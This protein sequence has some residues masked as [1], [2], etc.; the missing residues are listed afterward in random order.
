MNL[1]LTSTLALYLCLAMST[2]E[3]H[4][5]TKPILFEGTAVAGYVNQGAYLNFTGPGI[6]LSKKPYAVVIGLL[7]GLRIKKDRVATGATKNA[8]L[9]PSL[10]FGTTF[11]FQHF[12]IQIPL[13]YNAKT[14]SKNGEWHLG[15]GLGYKF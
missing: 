9:T 7:P 3:S 6:K 5:Q 15:A 4:S 2:F 13:Y 10:G 1:K 8:M 12:A 14:S 11:T